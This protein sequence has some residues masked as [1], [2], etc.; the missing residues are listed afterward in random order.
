MGCRLYRPHAIHTS[1]HKK[2]FSDYMGWIKTKN[3]LT[4]SHATVPL[5]NKL[6]LV[7][8]IPDQGEFGY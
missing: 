4:Q 6:S 3:H 1:L 8:N 5:I 7:G 2:K